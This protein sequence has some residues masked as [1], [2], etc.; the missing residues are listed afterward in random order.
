MVIHHYAL[1]PFLLKIYPEFFVFLDKSKS[2]P[3]NTLYYLADNYTLK[4]FNS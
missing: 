3:Q 4:Q 1:L 2:T